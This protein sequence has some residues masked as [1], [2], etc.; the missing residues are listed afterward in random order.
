MPENRTAIR[1]PRG[2]SANR[3][4]ALPASW[5]G[6]AVFYRLSG[7]DDAGRF[8]PG[9][10]DTRGCSLRADAIRP[11]RCWIVN[12]TADGDAVLPIWCIPCRYLRLAAGPAAVQAV[13]MVLL[14]LNCLHR[15]SCSRGVPWRERERMR[16]KRVVTYCLTSTYAAK[17]GAIPMKS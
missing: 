3:G 17:C 10:R 6:S 1:M 13:R 11:A 7:D 9:F 4:Y 16:V 14:Q 2:A 15:Q 8:L 5:V 12:L